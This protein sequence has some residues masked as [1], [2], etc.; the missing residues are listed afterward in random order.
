MA[1]PKSQA[2]IAA[3]NNLYKMLKPHSAGIAIF[4]KNETDFA[5]LSASSLN[6]FA[7]EITNV[8]AL[9]D[10]PDFADAMTAADDIVKKKETEELNSLHTELAQAGLNA[11][12]DGF[13]DKK[14]F[15]KLTKEEIEELVDIAIEKNPNQENKINSLFIPVLEMKITRE[16]EGPSPEESVE[17]F[18]A[19]LRGDNLPGGDSFY[20]NIAAAS[21]QAETVI[22][23]NK[24][25]TTP[26]Q[27][28]NNRVT[29]KDAMELKNESIKEK[30]A[31]QTWKGNLANRI[32]GVG[33]VLYA[34]PAIPI[35]GAKGIFNAVRSVPVMAGGALKAAW[36]AIRGN[37][38]LKENGISMMSAGGHM[39]L[40]GATAFVRAPASLIKEGVMNIATGQRQENTFRAKQQATRLTREKGKGNLDL[41]ANDLSHSSKNTQKIVEKM[42]STSQI[43]QGSHVQQSASTGKVQ[44]T[45]TRES[46]L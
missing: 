19:S 7:N 31:E 37:Q 12:E 22:K 5:A 38:E 16:R 6:A 45:N 10:S 40:Q 29:F 44:R 3:L 23:S 36:G 33:R 32:K 42:R 26:N 2:D 8:M 13:P 14:N 4:P 34:I 46:M 18:K 35:E 27:I 28:E 25:H 30:N 24:K 1:P 39:A 17:A 20:E 43:Q 21:R 15:A 11:R 9:N 41:K